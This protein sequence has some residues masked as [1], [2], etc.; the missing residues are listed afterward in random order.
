ME[1]MPLENFFSHFVVW[2]WTCWELLLSKGFSLSAS[3]LWNERS[4]DAGSNP[5]VGP[6][7]FLQAS[8]HVIGVFCSCTEPAANMRALE[9]ALF[10][11]SLGS[12]KQFHSWLQDKRN[13]DRYHLPDV[14]HNFLPY[15]NFLLCQSANGSDKWQHQRLNCP[16][17]QDFVLKSLAAVSH[18]PAW[19]HKIFTKGFPKTFSLDYWIL[20]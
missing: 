13:M 4:K 10:H 3:R 20:F 19:K 6:G 12:L 18:V 1:M 14:T 8:W 16:G 15:C 17:L 5:D 9:V 7:Q 2:V 11:Q